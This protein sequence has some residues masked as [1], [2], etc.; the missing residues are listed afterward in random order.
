MCVYQ[1]A[2]LLPSLPPTL[3]FWQDF[4]CNL[5]IPPRVSFRIFV[6]VKGGGGKHDNG[7]A[8]RGS[9]DYSNTSNAFSLV[10]NI[11][12]LIETKGSGGMLPRKISI[13][14]NVSSG[15]WD[16]SFRV[17]EKPVACTCTLLIP[18]THLLKYV[19]VYSTPR[20]LCEHIHSY[21]Y[22]YLL[23]NIAYM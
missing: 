2:T 12:E 18:W 9:K 10:R 4:W 7:R 5:R 14:E 21:M 15:F 19:H 11:I 3:C 22:V 20:N 8:K 13:S 1:W 6:K 23:E 17:G 16:R